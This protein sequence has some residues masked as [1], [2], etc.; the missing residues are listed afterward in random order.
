VVAVSCLCA[1]PHIHADEPRDDLLVLS[2]EELLN[3]KVSVASTQPETIS[4]TPAIVSTYYMKDLMR[5]GARSL[6]AALSFIPGVIVDEGTYGFSTVMVRG[7]QE[8]ANSEVLLLLDGI[9]YWSPSISMFTTLVVPVEAIDRIEVIRGPGA[10]IYGSNAINGVIN[11]ITRSRKGG[12]AALTVGSN[13]HRNLGGAII[14]DLGNESWIAV[15][16]EHQQ[17]EGFAGE[18]R[19]NDL[20]LRMPRP[21]EMSSVLV[22]Y[23]TR[24]L[25][26]LFQMH[27]ET[28]RGRVAPTTDSPA[29]LSELPQV[30]S[31]EGT[32]AHIDYTWRLRTSELKVYTDYNQ[33]P[34]DFHVPPVVL[35]FADE[36]DNSYRWRSGA[37]YA[38]DVEA[39]ERLSLLA[40]VEFERRRIGNYRSYLLNDQS[41]PLA[42]IMQADATDESA[43]YAQ[44]DYQ[45]GKWRC[46]AGARVIDNEKAGS[47]VAPRAS[48]VYSFTDEQSLKLLYAVGFTSPSFRQ[49]SSDVLGRVSGDPNLSPET[50][51][52]VD[53]A[54]T[55]STPRLLFVINAYS[56][57]ADDFIRLVPTPDPDYAVVY[58]NAGRFSR[59]GVEVDLKRKFK[60][61]GIMAN[62]SYNHEGDTMIDD[63]PTAVNVP[64]T[65]LNVGATY[66][67]NARNTLGATVQAVSERGTTDAYQ[68]ANVTYTY[69]KDALEA[70]LSLRNITEED[71]HNP[72][73]TTELPEMSHP[74]DYDKLNV[75]AGVA[76]HF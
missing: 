65:V 30:S 59:Q 43:V 29:P 74:K 3:V 33:Y 52:S 67:L 10:V 45:T 6:A 7:A 57:R 11:V 73:T 36:K 38:L 37:R 27:E 50:I 70:F 25:N 66:D 55:Y 56:Y 20:R 23:G 1:F 72:D 15:A 35:S 54:Y 53:L 34:L 49:S 48:V 32:L 41:T 61:W 2:L 22:R 24:N 31:L 62:A 69:R 28:M 13:N 64:Q 39:V 63:D 44:F 21:K 17:Q 14:E 51:A 26:L 58:S 18:Y 5:M 71:P 75:L 76:V 19:F 46:V 12:R 16:F 8:T 9:P 40:G 4:S 47:K 60:R 68:V 42:T